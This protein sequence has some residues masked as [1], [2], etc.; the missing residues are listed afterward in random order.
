MA[1]R[2]FKAPITEKFSFEFKFANEQLE[3]II[4][5]PS[6]KAA[7]KK[8]LK[9]GWRPDDC[10]CIGVYTYTTGKYRHITGKSLNKIF[11]VAM[12]ER[13]AELE[14]RKENFDA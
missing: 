7:V 13:K 12:A 4:F 6:L 3:D 9:L 1:E 2:F 8:Y 5:A 14:A 10:D 11:E